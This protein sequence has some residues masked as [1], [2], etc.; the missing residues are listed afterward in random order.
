MLVSYVGHMR[1]ATLPWIE[2][3]ASTQATDQRLIQPLAVCKTELGPRQP[4]Y[5]GQRG[6]SAMKV[7]Y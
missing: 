7:I 4:L 6:A 2:P 3:A 5:P 1:D